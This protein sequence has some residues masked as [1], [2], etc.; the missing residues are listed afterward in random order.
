ML[1]YLSYR[2][3]VNTFTGITQSN[4]PP[5][6]VNGK[7]V[8]NTGFFVRALYHFDSQIEGDL[9]FWKGDVIQIIEGQIDQNPQGSWLV[10]E[11]YGRRGKIP[12]NYCESVGPGPNVLCTRQVPSTMPN[13]QLS[14]ITAKDQA[15]FENRF[16]AAVGNERRLSG[17]MAR[18]MLSLSGLGGDTLSKIW[19][20]SRL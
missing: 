20:V 3:L 10:G 1:T 12:S 5:E 8:S 17:E 7:T 6:P 9:L 19:L 4:L 11:V 14:F 2:K 15:Q 18:D 16:F 13:V